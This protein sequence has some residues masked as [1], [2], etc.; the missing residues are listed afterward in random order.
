MGSYD[1]YASLVKLQPWF[2][3]LGRTAALVLEFAVK[4]LPWAEYS[5]DDD[6]DYK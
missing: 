4:D 3:L 1:T 6:D 5:D 2:L